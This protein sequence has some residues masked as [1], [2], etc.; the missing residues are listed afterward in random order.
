[1][2]GKEKMGIALERELEDD[3]H[4]EILKTKENVDADDSSLKRKRAQEF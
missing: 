1:M 2:E 4:D 3:E